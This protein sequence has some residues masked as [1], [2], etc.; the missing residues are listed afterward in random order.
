MDKQYLQLEISKEAIAALIGS[1]NLVVEDLR[2][3]NRG[4][5]EYLRDTVLLSLA[6]E[7]V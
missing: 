5:K 1:G 2:A 6:S 3:L 7:A 4:S